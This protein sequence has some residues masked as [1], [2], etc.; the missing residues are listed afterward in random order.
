M[1]GPRS[2]LETYDSRIAFHKHVELS[3]S[4]KPVYLFTGLCADL[5]YTPIGPGGF[6]TSGPNPKLRYWGDDNKNKYCWSTQDDAAAFT[7]EVL[8]KGAGVQEGRGGFFRFYSGKN[9]I[10]EFASVYE[11]VSGTKVEVVKEGSTQDLEAEL[12]RQRITKPLTSC[13]EWV[14]HATALL[15]I[16]GLWEMEN[17]TALDQGRKPSTLEAYVQKRLNKE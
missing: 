10:E 2:N 13:F 12:A 6:D 9:T 3:S 4:V 14:F 11:K 16:K 7:I 15:S 17:T 8:L 1:I 5:L